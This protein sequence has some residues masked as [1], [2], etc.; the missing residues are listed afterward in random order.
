[1]VAGRGRPSV[2]LAID[3][4]LRSVAKRARPQQ[5]ERMA[6][7]TKKASVRTRPSENASTTSSTSRTPGSRLDPKTF[8]RI[9]EAVISN[10][11]T[12]VK[13]K[14]DVARLAL[15]AMLS[16]GHILFEDVP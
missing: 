8:Q 4:F 14:T 2:A 10:V 16:E 13:G 11:G 5:G 3:R 1:M 9:F 7:T 6:T 15:V 12:V